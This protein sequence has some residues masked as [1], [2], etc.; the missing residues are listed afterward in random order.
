MKKLFYP[1][2][3]WEGLRKNRQLSRPYLLTCVCMVAVFYI[4]SF[5][6]SPIVLPL[7]PV[8]ASIV[9]EIMNLGR[10]VIMAFSLIFLYYTYSF[11]LRRR[12]REFGL[13]NVLG[14]GKRNLVRIITWENVITFA[15]AMTCGLFLGI[16]LSK[17]A[18]LGLVN[19]LGG[20]IDFVF[21]VDSTAIWQTVLFYAI[22]FGLLMLSAVI[23]TVRANAVSLMKTE[24]AGEKPPKGN[25]LFAILGVLILGGAYYIAITVKNPVTAILLFFIAVLMVI[26]A[27]YLLLVTGS[28]KLCRVLQSNKGYYYKAKHFVSVSSMAFRM[29]RTE[30]CRPGLHLHHRHDDPGHAFH[31]HLYVVRRGRF[32]QKNLPP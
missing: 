3:A 4:L 2:L 9:F 18:E 25:W 11:L 30:R 27:T 21:R 29:K 31:H 7:I 13:Y 20:T 6:A 5:L 32:P 16:L 26:L 24:N 14:M 1:R 12:S 28:V 15:I 17:L 23:R 19:L 22:I 8:G 10:Y